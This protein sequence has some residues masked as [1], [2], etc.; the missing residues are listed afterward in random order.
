MGRQGGTRGGALVYDDVKTHALQLGDSAAIAT[1]PGVKLNYGMG[2]EFNIHYAKNDDGA[3][4]FSAKYLYAKPLTQITAF[5]G[6]LSDRTTVP[7]SCNNT[8]VK[9]DTTTIGTTTDSQVTE[10][11]FTFNLNTVP[12]YALDGTLAAQAVYRPNHRTWVATVTRQY[13]AA[14]E[15]T[16]YVAKTIR[17]IRVLTTGPVL[18]AS[19]Y[20]IQQDLYGVWTNRTY[21]DVDG[22]ITEVLTL[23]PVF[24][25]ATSS[26][27][28]LLVTNA[29]AAI[30]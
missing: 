1:S 21:A 23:E 8:V 18:G 20:I 13:N 27:T 29:T 4:T 14:T 11:D 10:V 6:S 17:K 7:A 3:A 24:D 19:N 9:I 12:F 15:F 30:T 16:A 2:D 26:S 22:I 25:V 28:S 5:T